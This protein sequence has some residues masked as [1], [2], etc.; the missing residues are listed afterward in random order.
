M[1][2]LILATA[3]AAGVQPAFPQ[4]PDSVTGAGTVTYLDGSPVSGCRVVVRHPGFESPTGTRCD[5]E[6]R[7]TL[8]LG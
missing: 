1:T 8:L 5:D 3:L 2:V 7:Y 4:A 6:G